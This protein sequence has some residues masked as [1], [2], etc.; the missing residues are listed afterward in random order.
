MSGTVYVANSSGAGLESTLFDTNTNSR[1]L[2]RSVRGFACRESV[3]NCKC[4]AH[5]RNPRLILLLASDIVWVV[6]LWIG[7][8]GKIATDSTLDVLQHYTN[9]LWF[10][11]TAY[12]SVDVIA[13]LSQT[14]ALEFNLLFGVWWVV[15]PNIWVV[16]WLVFAMIYSNPNVITDNFEEN[17]GD[18]YAGAVLVGDRIFHVVTAIYSAWYFAW[19]IPDFVD[20]YNITFGDDWRHGTGSRRY[21]VIIY[22]FLMTLLAFLPFFIYYNSFNIKEVYEVTTPVWVGIMILVGSITITNVCGMAIMSPIGDAVRH[23][24]S[25]SWSMSYAKPSDL[26]RVAYKHMQENRAHSALR[27][28][29]PV[30]QRTDGLRQRRVQRTAAAR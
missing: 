6:I 5:F 27:Q 8:I 2:E 4:P 9:W 25:E 15:F 28:R 18:Y 10:M 23:S 17:G 12:Y 16:F 29:D 14:R 11:Q 30:D 1:F 22:I 13:L 21:G 19:R 26:D 3:A 7:T 24:F 20:I